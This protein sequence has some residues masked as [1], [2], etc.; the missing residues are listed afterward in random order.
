MTANVVGITSVNAGGRHARALGAADYAVDPRGQD[1]E[2][3]WTAEGPRGYGYGAQ[4]FAES[5][6]GGAIPPEFLGWDVEVWIYDTGSAATGGLRKVDFASVP[7][8]RMTFIWTEEENV[9]AA[10]RFGLG[11]QAVVKF[12]VWPVTTR[13]RGAQSTVTTTAGPGTGWA[14]GNT[15]TQTPKWLNRGLLVQPVNRDT[16]GLKIKQGRA[17][18][19]QD[20]VELQNSAGTVLAKVTSAGKVFGTGIDAGTQLGTNFADPV[21]PQDAV[22]KNY[23]DS[24]AAAAVDEVR[25]TPIL[26][27]AFVFPQATAPGAICAGL[28]SERSTS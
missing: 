21:D 26:S 14:K 28:A 18:V 12:V 1:I 8:R 15:Y 9:R 4:P 16:I 23:T 24:I 6:Y 2:I 10:A 20:F 13:G 25:S 19:A 27:L 3:W 17:T 22:T 11:F 7:N 5:D